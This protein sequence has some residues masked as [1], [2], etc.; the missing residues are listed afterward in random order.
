[1]SPNKPLVL[2]FAQTD[3]MKLILPNTSILSSH[4]KNWEGLHVEYHRQPP[5]ES[6]EHYLQQHSIG[7]I[8]SSAIGG[9]VMNGKHYGSEPCQSGDMSIMAAGTD[10]QSHAVEEHE[11]MAIALEPTDF[12]NTVGE[13]INSNLIEIISHWKIRDPLIFGIAWALKTELE[14]GGLNDTLYVDALKNALSVHL[15]H[16]YGAQKQKL[17]DIEGGLDCY[18]LQRVINYIN[19]YLNRDLHLTELAKLVQMS[20]YYFSRLFKQSTGSAP[21]NYVTQCRIKKAKQLLKI[22][23]LSIAY[24]SQEVGFSDHSHFSKTFCKIVGVT[25]KKYRELL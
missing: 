3:A 1:M 11:F 6:P 17:R 5:N 9:V 14:S 13:S 7:I 22:P 16:C 24:I 4:G 2:D 8:F 18:K 23:E 21:H 20:P 19:D 15:L 25:P 10:F 12:D